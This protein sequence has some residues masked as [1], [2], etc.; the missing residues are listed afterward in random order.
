MYA[1]APR[2]VQ[3][4]LTSLELGNGYTRSLHLDVRETRI[5][6]SG[7]LKAWVVPGIGGACIVAPAKP[8]SVGGQAINTGYTGC[9]DTGQ[10]L[11]QGLASVGGDPD[12]TE[13][14]FA[15]VPDGTTAVI[16]S[17]TGI[18]QTIPVVDNVILVAVKP[19]SRTLTLHKPG[20]ASVS[21]PYD[22]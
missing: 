1:S 10:I 20:G 7:S 18:G 13:L 14:A 17:R 16:H 9:G 22:V 11:R 12:G 5:V 8:G 21:F 4:A 15:L 3:R 6:R 19:D 2:L